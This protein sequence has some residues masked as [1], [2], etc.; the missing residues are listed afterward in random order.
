M[1]GHA[2]NVGKERHAASDVEDLGPDMCTFR[3][4]SNC[5]RGGFDCPDVGRAM[6]RD[7]GPRPLKPLYCDTGI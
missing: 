4:L 7:Q 6:F 5:L 1:R 3:G 2:T